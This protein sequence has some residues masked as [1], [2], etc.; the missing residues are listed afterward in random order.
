MTDLT[1]LTQIHDR[2]TAHFG[3]WIR[4]PEPSH[5]TQIVISKKKVMI[6][7]D[8]TTKQLEKLSCTTPEVKLGGK[9]MKSAAINWF[10]E[11][12]KTMPK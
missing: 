11:L 5:T 7:K 12:K 8:T 10:K 4:I 9:N 2:I 6:H 1:K 3:G